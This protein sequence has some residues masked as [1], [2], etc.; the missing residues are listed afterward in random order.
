VEGAPRTEAELMGRARALAGASLGA[1]AARLDLAVPPDLTRHKGWVGQLVERALGAPGSTRAGPDFAGL[2]VELKTLP[3]DASGAPRESTFVCTLPLTRSGVPWARSPARA[4]LGRVLWVPVEADPALP[5]A[6]RRVGSPLLWSPSAREDA[7]LAA[8][9]EDLSALLEAGYVESLTAHRG[10]ALQVRPK[11]A[12][13]AQR[14][15]GLDPDRE[16]VRTL[17][18]GLYLRRGFTRALLAAHYLLPPRARR[19]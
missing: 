12:D 1:L 4:K 15:W 7:E 6:A 13:A 18:R 17:P 9:W 16:A 10:R 5:L 14:T 11:A 8:D 19:A 2:G 3:V